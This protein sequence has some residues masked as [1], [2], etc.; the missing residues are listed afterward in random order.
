MPQKPAQEFNEEKFKQFLHQKSPKQKPLNIKPLSQ[1]FAEK[2]KKKFGKD[3]PQQ[4]EDIK[5]ENIQNLLAVKEETI[6]DIKAKEALKEKGIKPIDEIIEEAKKA[7]I[8]HDIEKD[9]DNKLLQE[10]NE[11]SFI[12]DEKKKSISKSISDKSSQDKYSISFLDDNEASKKIQ[13]ILDDFDIEKGK[14]EKEKRDT[15]E[16]IFRDKVNLSKIL[17]L[18]SNIDFNKKKLEKQLQTREMIKIK[19]EIEKYTEKRGKQYKRGSDRIALLDNLIE[20]KLNEIKELDFQIKRFE[21]STSQQF[22]EV[23][24]N[25]FKIKYGQLLK[26][27]EDLKKIIK[28][29]EKSK[30]EL[31]ELNN[32]LKIL[33]GQQKAE[34]ELLKE[35][36]EKE[37][38]ENIKDQINN[39]EQ[40]L[41]Q[42]KNEIDETNEKMFE[43]TNNQDILNFKQ[44]IDDI[45]EK[46]KKTIIKK[47]EKKDKGKDKFKVQNYIDELL[48]KKKLTDIETA[49]KDEIENNN[50][51]L[52]KDK[53]DDYKLNR[54]LFLIIK[55]K[56][57]DKKIDKE[58]LDHIKN[59][60]E[61]LKIQEEIQ[62]LVEKD[63]YLL[64]MTDI[65]EEVKRINK[66][67]TFIEI[68]AGIYAEI[69]IDPDDQKIKDL[70]EKKKA[71]IK[72]LENYK[73]YQKLVEKI[74]L[75]KAKIDKEFKV[76]QKQKELLEK[77]IDNN[78]KKVKLF[79]SIS[80]FYTSYPVKFLNYK[81][82]DF[83]SFFVNLY[84]WSDTKIISNISDKLYKA[85]LY[86]SKYFYYQSY[87]Y[88]IIN[89][90]WSYKFFAKIIT[91]MFLS[92]MYL[93]SNITTYTS[94]QI[95]LV[96]FRKFFFSFIKRLFGIDIYEYFEKNKSKIVTTE[97]LK[98]FDRLI[99]DINK[100]Q[101]K[102]KTK[103]KILNDPRDEI[104]NTIANIEMKKSEINNNNSKIYGLSNSKDLLSLFFK[105]NK[106]RLN[107]IET[108]FKQLTD[109]TKTLDD[110]REKS[111]DI[112]K[113]LEEYETKFKLDKG[114]YLSKLRGDIKQFYGNKTAKENEIKKLSDKINSA[115]TAKTEFDIYK[116]LLDGLNLFEEALKEKNATKPAN[117]QE[118]LSKEHQNKKQEYE[119]KVRELENKIADTTGDK[120]KLINLTS[121]KDKIVDL[122]NKLE[123]FFD[124][125]DSRNQLDA[126][127]NKKKQEI[128]RIK[129]DILILLNSLTYP[130]II[131][132]SK[133][134]IDDIDEIKDLMNDKFKLDKKLNILDTKLKKL[135][136]LQEKLNIP[137]FFSITNTKI[138]LSNLAQMAKFVGKTGI[139]MTIKP[140]FNLTKTA[141]TKVAKLGKTIIKE[142]KEKRKTKARARSRSSSSY[143]SSIFES[144]QQSLQSLQSQ[145][146][147]QSQS[148][149][150][151]PQH[152]IDMY[153]NY[154]R[155]DITK[156]KQ[157]ANTL[158]EK[159]D[160]NE[161]ISVYNYLNKR[162]H[163][164][165]FKNIN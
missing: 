101:E 138:L 128:K 102:Y 100:E 20:K 83:T 127:I 99:N 75:D 14:I 53:L 15:I 93:T 84:F 77:S 45:D 55:T 3:F 37:Q 132:F 91:I 151:P 162:N 90:L 51:K 6:A 39:K 141:L 114:A 76:L 12:K 109:K 35:L 88:S 18:I 152:L 134:T 47:Y 153:R 52:S 17:K 22:D 36:N 159:K 30:Q 96:L 44:D 9:A 157:N 49:I 130:Q 145:Q 72:L 19:D 57:K 117:Q 87:T 60:I 31:V 161:I 27:K 78:E 46:I 61:L 67:F 25:G 103:L 50:K 140:L 4:F 154:S 34:S 111:A 32:K 54:K 70:D 129:N 123:V 69:K 13:K 131:K 8:K 2:Y 63:K 10:Y 1:D 98:Y 43:L 48:A 110:T 107:E 164:K 33:V 160:I 94:I 71:L 125:I 11:L 21:L 104:N 97:N 5:L 133:F 66:I 74:N 64:T 80:W 41:D 108:L 23:I 116:R 92:F 118:Q 105:T 112:A 163:I 106:Q 148:I 119:K 65:E 142:I 115:T 85:L 156:M 89:F 136:D 58:E 143:S 59:K 137:N 144:A 135:K 62:K 26:R 150:K 38:T 158:E 24:K 7:N 155:S 40:L 124:K 95:L 139:N 121:R 122:I 79:N 113:K 147:K 165:L 82:Y 126:E 28:T 149:N 146:S 56:D 68:E 120:I 29:I 81:I 16:E 42:I 86:Y 73:R